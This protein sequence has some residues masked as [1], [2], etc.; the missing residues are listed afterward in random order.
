LPSE[1]LPATRAEDQDAVELV[2]GL[3]NREE[4]AIPQISQ[5]AMIVRLYPTLL[6]FYL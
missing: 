3:A 6:D 5:H 1:V 4:E 2:Q